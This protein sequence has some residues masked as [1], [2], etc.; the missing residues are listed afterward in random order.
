MEGER[1]HHCANPAPLYPVR[2]WITDP[3]S[4]HH[5]GMQPKIMFVQGQ[6]I[7]SV[8]TNRIIKFKTFL[9]QKLFR[10]IIVSVKAQ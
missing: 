1:S 4:D 2:S 10:I 7:M 6:Q 9:L 3:D 8:Y 5:N